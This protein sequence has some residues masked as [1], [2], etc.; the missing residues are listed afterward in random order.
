MLY[1][2]QRSALLPATKFLRTHEIML[3][4]SLWGIQPTHHVLG[5]LQLANN[6]TII[7]VY[8]G[9]PM[10]ITPRTPRRGASACARAVCMRM[11]TDDALPQPLWLELEVESKL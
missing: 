8:D 6:E 3:G 7:L 11:C 9:S 10:S 2:I 4:Y 5:H 1:A